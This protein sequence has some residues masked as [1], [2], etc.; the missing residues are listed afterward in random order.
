MSDVPYDVASDV[1]DLDPESAVLAPVQ[2]RIEAQLRQHLEEVMQQIYEVKNELSKAQKEREQCGVELYNSQQHLAKLQETLEKCHEKHLATK[3]KHEEK[4]Q[5]RE[6]LAAQ[7]DTLRKNIEDQ[8]RQY[9]RQQADLLKLTETLVKVQQFNEQ[10]KNEVQVERRAAF[11]TEEDITNL[12]KEK[13]KQ[14]NLID[15]LEKRVVLLEEEIS[16]VNSQ[17]ENQQRETQKAREILAE[18]LAEMEAINFEKKQLVQQWKG[19]LIGMQRRHEAMKKTEE[20]LQQQ[21][22]ELQVLENEIIGTRKDIKGV[23]AE[24]AKLAEFMSRVDN[25]VTVLGKQIDVLVERKEKGAREYV[26]LKDNIEQ[27]DA[28]AKK[29]EYEARTYSTEAA[30]IEKKMLKVSKEVVLMENDILESLGKQSSLKQECH[31]TLSDIEKMKGSIRSK[32]LQVAQMENELARIRV[33][34][35]QAQSHNETLKTTLG[36]LEKELQAR[37]LMVERMQMDIHRR[38]DEIDRKQKQLDQLN[39]QYEQLVAAY[40]ADKGEH[41]G[42]LEA[43]IN[44]LSK[45]IA[46]KV[47][48]NEALQQEWIKLQTELVN[49]KNNSNEVNEAILELQAQSTVLTQKRDR[50]LVN[51]SNEKKDIAN[52][53]NKAN[54]MHLEMKRVN[55]QLCK[56]SDDQK[57]VANEAFLL[58]NDLIRRLQEKKREAIVLEQKVEEARQAKTELLE[59]I[60][61]HESD[62]LFWERKMQVAKETEMALDPSVGKAEVEKMRKEIGIMEQRVSHLQREQRFLIEEMQKSIDHR[63]IIRAKGQAIQEAAKVN[64]RGVTRMDIEKESSRMFKELNEK[65]QEAQLK[66]RQIKE[67][68]ASIEKTTAEAESVQRE[69][70]TLDEQISELRSQLVVAQ[71]E[72]DRLEDERRAKNSSLQRIRDAEK[73]T[74]KSALELKHTAAEASRL[75]EKRRAFAEILGELTDKY[76][77]LADDLSDIASSLH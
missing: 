46:E 43:T 4:L 13:L 25:E 12:E 48:E 65:R 73:G 23:Q 41:V 44:S 24:T 67:R 1:S 9:E 7:A 35:L 71:K 77:E 14:D 55:T 69:I 5:E 39:H 8:Q 6:E 36:D 17:V 34:T 72:H 11:K 3:Q 60:M 66:E 29:L 10:L 45:A 75:N 42:P 19:T 20:A 33:D 32:E 70:D 58:E 52:L 18:A 68:L 56:N 26:M 63:E 62:I 15:S 21:K 74:Y 2:K 31:G 49:C 47:N 30:D 50:L 38:H 16:T 53:E 40:G 59:Q 64:K 54:A 37:G 76:P 61:N 51:I 22:D 27:T 57:N 28:E